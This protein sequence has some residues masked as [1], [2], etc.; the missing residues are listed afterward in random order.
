M[1]SCNHEKAQTA[2]EVGSSSYSEDEF[3]TIYCTN[4]NMDETNVYESPFADKFKMT[5]EDGRCLQPDPLQ[6]LAA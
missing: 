1:E 6:E 3:E 2:N 4:K 5:E